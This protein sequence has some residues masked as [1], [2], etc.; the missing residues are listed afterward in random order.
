MLRGFVTVAAATVLVA[1]VALLDRDRE[2]APVDV[3]FAGAPAEEATPPVG[4]SPSDA[5]SASF[6]QIG[7]CI[8]AD[9]LAADV[10]PSPALTP[11]GVRKIAARVERL[12]RLR[13]ERA[14][15]RL[16]PAGRSDR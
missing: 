12:R 4:V 6:S 3:V 7:G 11:S 10:P 13:F 2:R 9:D 1:V 5:A 15:R 16:V 8:G 14:R